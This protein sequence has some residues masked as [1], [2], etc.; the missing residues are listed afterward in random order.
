MSQQA[1]FRAQGWPQARARLLP[2]LQ[3]VLTNEGI[4]KQHLGRC[5]EVEENN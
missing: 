4:K 5:Y 2:W 1:G 3:S